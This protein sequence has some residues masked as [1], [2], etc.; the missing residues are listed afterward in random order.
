MSPIQQP[1]QEKPKK[2]EADCVGEGGVDWGKDGEVDV[3]EYPLLEGDVLA[4]FGTCEADHSHKA[5]HYAGEDEQGEGVDAEDDEGF[6]PAF[7]AFDVDEV[8]AEGESEQGEAG[9]VNDIGTRPERLV[10]RK[11]K[12]P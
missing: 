12:A 5:G 7:V 6:G 2:N 11:D 4:W 9:C 3:V 8:I 10:Q 1:H